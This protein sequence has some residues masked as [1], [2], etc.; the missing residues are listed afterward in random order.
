MDGKKPETPR[1]PFEPVTRCAT[2]APLGV[3]AAIIAALITLY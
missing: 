3:V 1:F 2:L